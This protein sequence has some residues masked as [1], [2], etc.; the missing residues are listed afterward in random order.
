MAG[1]DPELFARA[2]AFVT[3]LGGMASESYG[4]LPD[5]RRRPPP[6]TLRDDWP[7]GVG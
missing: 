1:E 4:R 3:E 2:I 5:V 7:S 6:P